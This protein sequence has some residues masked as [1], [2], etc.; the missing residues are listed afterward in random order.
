MIVIRFSGYFFFFYINQNIRQEVRPG[1]LRASPKLLHHA[2][3]FHGKYLIVLETFDLKP[4]R[5]TS[6][7]CYRS[8]RKSLGSNAL[9]PLIFLVNQKFLP[10][11]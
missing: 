4:Q 5:S 1:E 9:E 3:E 11:H 8:Q 7:W 10:V 6:L 2:E